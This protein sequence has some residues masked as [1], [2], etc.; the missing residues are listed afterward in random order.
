MKL[1]EEIK[2]K[3]LLGEVSSHSVWRVPKR[4]PSSELFP[5]PVLLQHY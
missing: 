3:I 1:W 5:A 4:L 2:E